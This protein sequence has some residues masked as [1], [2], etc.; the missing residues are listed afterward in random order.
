MI[1]RA[2]T[3]RRRPR[4]PATAQQVMEAAG[5][6]PD[7]PRRRAQVD[8]YLV[9]LPAREAALLAMLMTDAGHLVHRA[10][11]A[12][13]AGGIDRAHRG[14]LDRQLCRLRRRL[15]PS[16]LSPP[17]LHRIGHDGYL[18]G[19]SA[20]CTDRPARARLRSPAVARITQVLRLR[21]H[22]LGRRAA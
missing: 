11:L 21:L 4:P 16:P 12:D 18:F 14:D 20:G 6:V 10:V 2:T 7:V 17:R 22:K 13:A 9:H 3:L 8:G 19:S 15:E 5:V 1:R